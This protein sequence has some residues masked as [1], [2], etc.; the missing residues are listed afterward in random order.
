SIKFH[1]PN[2]LADCPWLTYGRVRPAY[3][4][5]VLYGFCL[6]SGVGVA[7]WLLARLG[8]VRLAQPW[9][10]T[11]GAKL[12]NLG[13]TVGIVGIL[14]A[15]PSGFEY[16]EM[17]RYAALVLFLAW[18][19]LGSFALLTFHQRREPGLFVS[20]WFLLRAL[21]RFPWIYSTAN[22]LLLAFPVRGMAQPV[23]AWWYAGNLQVVWLGLVGL[24]V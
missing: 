8:R 3:L 23:I 9:L 14:A 21:F 17:P 19:L 5:C 7:L 16:L 2:F 6:Q 10:V 1:A 11:L 18:L 20:Q 22:L 12:W 13:V 24:A 4:N 15:G